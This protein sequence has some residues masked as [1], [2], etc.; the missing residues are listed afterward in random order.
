MTNAFIA[1]DLG[2]SVVLLADNREL[3]C[4]FLDEFLDKEAIVEAKF[5]SVDTSGQEI[6]PVVV[7]CHP[8]PIFAPPAP[9]RT[10][11]CLPQAT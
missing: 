9:L 4:E 1:V 6:F 3:P 7:L 5:Q 10:A 8:M 2:T 11:A